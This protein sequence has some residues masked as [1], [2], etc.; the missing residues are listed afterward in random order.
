MKKGVKILLILAAV[1]A[2]LCASALAAE[3]EPAESGVCGMTAGSSVTL[4]MLGDPAEN[5]NT[6]IADF[7]GGVNTMRIGGA[8]KTEFYPGVVRV[9]IECTGLTPNGQY[10]L[11]MLKDDGSP[12]PTEDNIAYLNQ[13]AAAD[14]SISFIAYPYAMEAGTYRFYI[15]G[16]GKAFNAASPDA[17][18]EYYEYVPPYVLGDPDSNGSITPADALCALQYYVGKVV[19]TET[20]LL[21]ADVDGSGKVTPTDALYILQKYVGKLDSFDSVRNP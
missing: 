18:V 6:P 12:V 10:I 8:V 16:Q 5:G 21:A 1:A 7:L 19:P 13:D 20:Q 14:G 15:V 9:K 2:L 17:T 3:L 11:F 4:T